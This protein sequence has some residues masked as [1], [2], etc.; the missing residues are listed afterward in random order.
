MWRLNVEPLK[1]VG[2]VSMMDLGEV[3]EAFMAVETKRSKDRAVI[4]KL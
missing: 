1:K 2:R 3:H 4:L